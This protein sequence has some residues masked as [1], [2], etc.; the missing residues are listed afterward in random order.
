MLRD[1][2]HSTRIPYDPLIRYVPSD[3]KKSS[4]LQAQCLNLSS[5]GLALKMSALP[6]KNNHIELYFPVSITS[7]QD[8]Q[9]GQKLVPALAEKIW[10]TINES[11]ESGPFW[12]NVGYRLHFQNPEDRM[13]FS[14]NYIDL[15]GIVT[16]KPDP[17][18]GFVF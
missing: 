12:V 15:G 2:R 16:P 14:K 10:L 5:E 3:D 17:R 4:L 13:C 18:I 11:R 7:T 9:T 1:L 8:S 6:P